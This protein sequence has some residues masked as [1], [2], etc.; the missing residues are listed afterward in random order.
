MRMRLVVCRDGGPHH[1]RR[2]HDGKALVEV[3][4]RQPCRVEAELVG[5][6][7]LGNRVLVSLAPETG[8][9]RRAFD[10][11]RRTSWKVPHNVSTQILH[12]AATQDGERTIRFPQCDSRNAIPDTKDAVF[13]SALP[14]KDHVYQPSKARSL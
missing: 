5:Q 8:R 3:Q 13:A 11:R 9:Q 7:R 14:V 12:H 10:R 4:F 2:R 1:H 6:L